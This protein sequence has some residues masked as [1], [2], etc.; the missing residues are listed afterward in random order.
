MIHLCIMYM[1]VIVPDSMLLFSSIHV[2][3]YS[4]QSIFDISKL[5]S[6]PRLAQTVPFFPPSSFLLLLLYSLLFTVLLLQVFYYSFYVRTFYFLPRKWERTFVTGTIALLVPP[7][8]YKFPSFD[9]INIC[10]RTAFTNMK[11]HRKK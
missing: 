1:Y 7:P 9:T 3:Q 6:S 8:L 4:L 2:L 5:R 11:W 10:A